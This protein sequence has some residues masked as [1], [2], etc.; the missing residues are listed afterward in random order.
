[1]K[2]TFQAVRAVAA[3]FARRIYVPVAVVIGVV[4]A[5]IV[6]LSVWLT[7]LSAWW[8]LLFALVLLWTIIVGLALLIA[9][10]IIRLL[11]PQ[12]TQRQKRLVKAFVEKLQLL[13]DVAQTPKFILLFKLVLD[14]ARPRRDGFVNSVSTA[15]KTIRADFVELTDSFS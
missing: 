7:T 4:T 1:M 14:I 5:A 11:A 3:L 8:W 6:I 15:T 2:P 12:Q 10:V 9:G 13:S